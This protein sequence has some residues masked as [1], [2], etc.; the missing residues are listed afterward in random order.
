MGVRFVYHPIELFFSSLSSGGWTLIKRLL[1]NSS[2]NVHQYT[3]TS[4]YHHIANYTD[5]GILIT[6]PALSELRRDMGFHQ[7]RFY[8]HKK[9]VGRVFHIMTKNDSK[10]EAV[11]KYYTDRTTPATA[12]NS[13][14]RLPDDRSVLSSKC[15]SWGYTTP[16]KWGFS[17]STGATRMYARLVV[18]PFK[19]LVKVVKSGDPSGHF[20]DDTKANRGALSKGDEWKIFVR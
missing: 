5:N 8:C 3:A 18:V 2:S 17:T 12:C 10:G 1:L 4:D 16:N 20:C 11:V 6:A 7:F 13:F 19:N 15:S 14:T 9:S